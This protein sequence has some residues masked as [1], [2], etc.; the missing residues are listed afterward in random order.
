MNN[1]WRTFCATLLICHSNLEQ[2]EKECLVP[3]ILSSDLTIHHFLRISG[4]TPKQFSDTIKGLKQ[5]G[6]VKSKNKGTLYYLNTHAFLKTIRYPETMLCYFKKMPARFPRILLFNKESVIPYTVPLASIDKETLT[7]KDYFDLSFNYGIL[8][9][10]PK[11]NAPVSTLRPKELKVQQEK[12]GSLSA[13]KFWN[14][15]GKSKTKPYVPDYSGK[16]IGTFK[17]M[18]KTIKYDDLVNAI[19]N[20]Y[21]TS[22]AFVKERRYPIGLFKANINYYLTAPKQES[23]E[24]KRVYPRSFYD[25]QPTDDEF[26]R[27]TLEE[28]KAGM[29][30]LE[31]SLY[32]RDKQKHFMGIVN[33]K[34][35][36][37]IKKLKADKK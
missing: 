24:N 29:A 30:S 34:I 7:T 15:C 19:Q 10:L 20:Y 31:D 5:R 14:A 2:R 35:V 8:G 36:K 4:T 32:V 13:T 23:K 6:V 26:Y 28:I 25:L 11:K 1:D 9:K 3:F 16:T 21:N 18:L 17:T 22:E 33:I 37:Y 27:G 12:S